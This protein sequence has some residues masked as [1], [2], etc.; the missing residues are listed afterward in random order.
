[1]CAVQQTS[2][3]EGFAALE[4]LSSSTGFLVSVAFAVLFAT[5]VLHEATGAAAWFPSWRIVSLFVLGT[6][7]L[8]A[9]RFLFETDRTSREAVLFALRASTGAF[10]LAFLYWSRAAGVGEHGFGDLLLVVALLAGFLLIHRIDRL[11][12]PETWVLAILIG[13]VMAIFFYHAAG[14]GTT[15]VRARVPYWAGVLMGICLLVLPRYVPEPVFL[16]TASQGTAIV[17]VLG[18][19]AYPFGAYSLGPLAVEPWGG[20]VSF[21]VAETDVMRSIFPNPN[22]FAILA[23][24]G[25]FAALVELRRA[26]D[27]PTEPIALAVPGAVLA[28]NALG[29]Y[30][31]HA[32]AGLLAAAVSG[33]IYVAYAA[34]GRRVLPMAI[35]ASL[36]TVLLLLATMALLGVDSAHR[37]ELWRGSVAAI[38]DSPSL[39]GEGIVATSDV[40]EPYLDDAAGHTPHNSYLSLFIRI[41]LVGGLVYVLFTVGSLA[42]GALF[43]RT[44]VAM[45]A[46]ASGFT[47]HQLFEVYS[48]F[49]VSMGAVLA[50]LVFGYLLFGPAEEEPEADDRRA[51]G[52][53]RRAAVDDGGLAAIGRH[54]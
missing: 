46:L 25:T 30:L 52:D 53:R 35:A 49:Q 47:V 34:Y 17:V 24:V 38:V 7:A 44:N 50:A 12:E 10:L 6:I 1:M 8:S 20:S 21:L 40:I 2:R 14:M 26:F 41:G 37:F 4:R 51:T 15:S 13:I 36:S 28:V 43:E 5:I 23:F 22:T 48:L 42:Y 9:H 54:K 31:S 3:E 45:L 29:L 11:P 27:G 39:F 16:A 33:A 18:L 19:L 32:R